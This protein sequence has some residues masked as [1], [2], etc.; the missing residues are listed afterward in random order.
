[1]VEMKPLSGK[2]RACDRVL[3]FLLWFCALLTCALL[4][5]IIGYIFV[6]GLPPLSWRFLTSEPSFFKDT[7]GILPNIINTSYLVVVPLPTT[8]PPCVG[9]AT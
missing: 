3:R 6:K 5:F 8:R 2:R 9:P 4:V 7:I 1:M